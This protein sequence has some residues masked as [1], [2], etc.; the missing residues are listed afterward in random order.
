MTYGVDQCRVCGVPIK[1]HRPDEITDWLKAQKRPLIPEHEWR[2]RGFL[3][4]PTREQLFLPSAGCCQPC[5]ER[6]LRKRSGLGKRLAVG[7]LSAAAAVAII[8]VVQTYAPYA[9]VGRGVDHPRA[10]AHVGPGIDN[11]PPVAK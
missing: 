4:A 6:L 1:P 10:V 7:A 2:R 5:G 11:T 8:W 9:G 3:A